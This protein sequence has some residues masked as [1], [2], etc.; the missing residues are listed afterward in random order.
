MELDGARM[1][2]SVQPASQAARAGVAVGVT[3][4]SVNEE[5]LEAGVSLSDVFSSFAVGAEVRLGMRAEESSAAAEPAINDAESS[6]AASS[7]QL[8]ASPTALQRVAPA[9]EI[10]LSI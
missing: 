4:T 9:E 1:V 6:P 8:E 10:E 5:P 7:A 2:T 3:V